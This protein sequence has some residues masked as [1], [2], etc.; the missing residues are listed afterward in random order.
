[1]VTPERSSLLSALA[2]RHAESAEHSRRVADLAVETARGLLPHR[3]CY[4][5]EIAAL[6]HDIGKI[7]VPDAT[8]LK[9]GPLSAE[10]WRLMR[11]HEQIGAELVS[12]AFACQE[13]TEIVSS[14][15]DWYGDNPERPHPPRKQGASLE[16]RILSIADAFDAMVS[17]RVYR[18]ATSRENAFAEL[19]RCAGT[20]FDPELVE[21][22]I[23]AVL[24]RDESR[25]NPEV[26]VSKQT[27]LKIGVEIEKLADALDKRNVYELLDMARRLRSA[28]TEQGIPEIARVAAELETCFESDPD[29]VEIV[30][31]TSQLLEL[32]RATQG[33]CPAT[34]A[35]S[36]AASA[37]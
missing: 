37:P 3:Q 20:Q 10:E 18:K 1:M 2:H 16:A 26:C 27:A 24:A 22:F 25:A 17:N 21:R 35:G 8:L 30:Q 23:S 31:L 32:C 13:L 12:A 9:P 6:L 34:G 33:A 19:R 28:A 5:L 29:L 14:C 36:P 7:G 15:H 4:V 11:A